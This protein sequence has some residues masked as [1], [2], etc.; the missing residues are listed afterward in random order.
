MVERALPRAFCFRK[1]AS[2]R[3]SARSTQTRGLLTW[4]QRCFSSPTVRE[5]R[6]FSRA[7]GAVPGLAHRRLSRERPDHTLQTTALV[8]EAY[9]RLVDQ[10]EASW[11]N[12][13]QFFAVAAQMMRRVLVDYA[14]ARQYKKRGGG[15][16]QVELDEAMVESSDRAA[17]VVAL[18]EVLITLAELDP[19]KSQV[20]EL[21]FFGGLSIEE[22]AEILGVSPGTVMR[23][24]TLAKAWLQREMA[25]GGPDA[26]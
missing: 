2:V 8:H 15:A 14:R 9:L 13:S 7:P 19:R 12:R 24:W 26:G 23:D 5:G 16:Q 17:E 22:T 4:P 20:V 18:D 3:R 10:Q 21:R 1:K 11:K 6:N 25:Q